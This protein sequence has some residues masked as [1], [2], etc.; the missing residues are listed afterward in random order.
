VLVDEA[1]DTSPAQWE[2]ID[3][4]VSEF[5]AGEGA[6]DT[7]RTLFVVGDEKQSIYSFQGAEPRAFGEMRDHFA[8]RLRAVGEGLAEGALAHSFRSAPP[9]LAFVDAVMAAAP[10]ATDGG[11]GARH[12]AFHAEAPGRV[13]L[14]PHLPKTEGEEEP[15]W[16]EPCDLPAPEHPELQLA[17][18]TAGEV[19]RLLR[20]GAPVPDRE[21]GPR[22]M[23]PGDVLILVRRRRTLFQALIRELKAAGVPV[24]GADRM[25]LTE[26]IAV[27]D[28]LAGLRF[29]ATPEDD[30]SLAAFLR[31]PLGGL[32]E[33]GLFRLAH[34]RHGTLWQALE[35]DAR[36]P[37][38]TALALKLR[39][40]A[41]FRRPFEALE[42]LLTEA[43]GRA[44]LRARLGDEIEEAVDALLDQALAYES[45][46]PPT[47]LGFL[48]WLD[49][50]ETELKRELERGTGAVR[51]MTVHGAKGLEA[52]VVVLPD[53]APRNAP[54]GG[55]VLDLG[56]RAGWK[57]RE[58]AQ[59]AAQVAAEAE[60]K[61]RA[62]A[63]DLRLF[64]VA[65]TRA[66]SW[67]ILGAA[68]GRGD[69][70]ESWHGRAAA[71]LATLGPTEAAAPEG[72][73]GPA[74][75]LVADWPA[76]AAGA[77]TPAPAAPPPLPDW[78]H[79]APPARVE[80]PQPRAPSDLGGAH[81]LP[82]AEG[83]EG[84]EAMA[85]GTLLHTLIE[86]LPTLP[87]PDRAAAAMALAA[88]APEAAALIAEAEAVIAAP[89]L[90]PLFA[91]DALIE[92]EVAATLPALG[93]IRGRI[94]RLVVTPTRILAADFKSNRRVPATAE[95][96]P[97]ALLRQMG[98]YAAA[99]SALYPD[100]VVETALVW[101]R[102]AT[103]MPL[104]PALTAAALTRAGADG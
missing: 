9:I 1:Q 11:A 68:G 66:E 84:A 87:A 17:R 22:P 85:R 40:A 93:P 69:L 67:L 49:A 100:R 12:V 73:P 76:I 71:A 75:E 53:C 78:A 102:T 61:A 28:L 15:P 44:R 56:G 95:A 62:A 63:E 96:V 89:S 42:M 47:L 2:V 8:A 80:P 46:E 30:L 52:P 57:Q 50:G 59:P 60:R 37:E 64:Y 33:D 38:A 23:R 14:W 25:R 36:W 27:Q 51:I 31:S 77:E 24:A 45:V 98:A 81:A 41:D 18:I 65:M 70:A 79:H 6:R 72:L 103:L 82:G 48:A 43:G 92:V 21:E 54:Q 55:A 39:D 91:P 90:A 83:D 26:E 5:Q 97:E 3:A 74:L 99:L 34:G 104:P 7:A 86:V 29:A 10:E 35:G 13:T 88:G 101:T 16:Y 58:E 32:S 94:D 19:A 20:E 4:I